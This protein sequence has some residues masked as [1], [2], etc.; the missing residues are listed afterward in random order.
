MTC[1]SLARSAP[2]LSFLAGRALAMSQLPQSPL[3]PQT[4]AAPNP[5][6]QDFEMSIRAFSDF[7]SPSP[8]KK[9]A[10]SN[11]RIFRSS[12]AR[13]GILFKT[14]AQRKPDRRVHFAPLP[15]EQETCFTE[16]DPDEKDAIYDEEDISYFDP[17]G[18]KTGTVR[19][20]KPTRRTA[21]PPPL[22]MSSVEVWGLPDHDQKFA[23]HFEAMSK[24][25]KPSRKSLRLLPSE[26]QQIAT[27]SQEVGAMAEAFIQ[28]SQTRKKGLELAAEKRAEAECRS[29]YMEK[30]SVPAAM[31]MFQDQENVEPVDDVSLVLDNL[32]K[33]LD[34]TWGIDMGTAESHANDA[35][36][37]QEKETAPS[38]GATQKVED[39]MHALETNVWAE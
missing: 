33:F 29:G 8:V 38:Q 14:P 3:G 11:G 19:M 31:D 1:T 10:S 30:T 18:R 15:G 17:S 28:A 5:P 27:A 22:E 6:A 12:S 13:P 7:M 24:R 25:K 32:D 21:S 35:C 34:N 9:R 37:S 16:L 36:S 20:P 2:N 4:P 39:P 26:S 23:K